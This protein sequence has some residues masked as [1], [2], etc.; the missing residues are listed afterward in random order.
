[1]ACSA[2]VVG[3]TDSTTIRNHLQSYFIAYG[4]KVLASPVFWTFWR[5]IKIWPSKIDLVRAYEI[6]WS[7]ILIE[8]GFH[9]EALYLAGMHGNSTHTCWRELLIEYKFPFIKTELLRVNPI[10]QNIT[11]WQSVCKSV[12]PQITKMIAKHLGIPFKK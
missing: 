4:P 1:M 5:Q 3:L 9:L 6:G 2:D 12:N 10:R 11:D 7:D 8:S